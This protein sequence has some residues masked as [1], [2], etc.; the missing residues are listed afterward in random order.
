MENLIKKYFYK[1]FTHKEISHLLLK[2]HG[3]VA[4]TTTIKRTLS[5]LGLK[6]KQIQE[7]NIEDICYA[8]IEELKSA[9]YNLGYRSLWMKLKKKY[10]LV[11]KR[12]TVYYI[13]RIADPEGVSNRL[14]NKLRRR[15]YFSPGPNFIWHLDGYDKLKPFGFA[16]HGCIDGFSRMIL[17]LEIAT[18]NNNP[19]VIGYYFLKTVFDLEYVPTLIRSDK[20][21]ENTLVESLQISLRTEYHQD[22]LAGEKS[23]IKGKSVHN[24]RIESFWGQMRRHSVD[25]FI[26]FFKSMT[27][28]GLFD[29]SDLHKKCLQFCF[30]P[31]IK[32]EL[33]STKILW[34]EHRI[35][36]QAGSNIA[37]KPYLLFNIPDKY[38]AHDCKKNVDKT[39]IKRL[40]ETF[41]SKPHL[42]ESD[43]EELFNLLLPNANIPSTVEEALLVYELLLQAIDNNNN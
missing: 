41:T 9:G 27:E 5:S 43:M 34:N 22:N 12:D 29:G 8:V 32:A 15:T 42:Y 23:Y 24:Q 31:L 19:A 7:S 33:N 20:G 25:F 1:N 3:L 11:V 38:N 17:W 6:R 26:Q 35:R 30:A 36:K 14:A 37:G 21:S 18:T 39:V 40:M 16:I 13:L 4:S 2:K 28:K 10:K